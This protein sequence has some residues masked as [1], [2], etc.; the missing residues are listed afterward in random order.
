MIN[1]GV[2]LKKIL[3][4]IGFLFIVL[5]S[6]SQVSSKDT[7]DYLPE[8]Y[9]GAIDYNL[10]IAASK[11][12]D[13]EIERLILRGADVEAETEDGATALT[14][15]VANIKPF[16]VNT[17]LM[18]NSDPNKETANHETP[19]LIILRRLVTVEAR[20]PNVMT[21]FLIAQCLEIAESLIRYGADIDFQDNYGVTALNYASVYG[22][23]RFA[24]LLLYYMAD[25][26][27]KANDG[28]TP[29][30]AAIWGG[31]ANIADLLV[32]NGANL[33]ARD[34]IGFTPFLT[35]AQNGDTL[36][37]N[38]LLKKGVDIYE[39]DYNGW[40][41]L[42]LS[43]KH[44][45]MDAVR[46]LVEAGDKWTSPERQWLNY[47]NVAVKFGREEILEI[48][49]DK[50]F[51]GKY[52]PR[53]NQMNI[54][55][56]SK[57]TTRDI[58]SGMSFHFTEPRNRI[59]FMGGFDTKLWQTRV[60]VKESK[61]L[62]YQY[63]D[64]SSIIYAGLFKDITLTENPLK[65]NWFLSGSLSC[66]Y[67]FGNR[68]EGTQKGPEER[69]LI[70]PAVSLKWQKENVSIFGSLEYTRTGFYKT[71]PFWLRI[72]ISYNFDFLYGRT[73]VKVIRW[74]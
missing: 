29:L 55:I 35:A 5:N 39:T 34:D 19:L 30:M 59:G 45:H 64:K 50:D 17:L 37:I 20:E 69:L 33:E 44:N 27:K 28:T 32:Q 46:L 2:A 1:G 31:H 6:F 14:I 7:I 22:N 58:Y 73:P 72:G 9:D 56:S 60:L 67:F 12:L 41:A 74:Y 16:A 26:D 52:S 63:P 51:P 43:I 57:L 42:S 47:Y 61:T 49:R 70:L 66:G 24:D 4:S 10:M 13:T 65:S 15:A 25:I 36:L 8:F 38:Y 11:G 71:G 3:T 53:I 48:L 68:F 54:T 23:F 18:Y 62:Y 40:D 21:E